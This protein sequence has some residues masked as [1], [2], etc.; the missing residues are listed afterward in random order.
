M[1]DWISVHDRIPP[2][3][4]YVLIGSATHDSVA[5]AR[6]VNSGMWMV[7]SSNHPVINREVTHWMPLPDPPTEK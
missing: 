1:K 3:G 6:R 7:A 5:S 2:L 4:E